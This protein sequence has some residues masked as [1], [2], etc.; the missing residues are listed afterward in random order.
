MPPLQMNNTVF[1][2]GFSVVDL[3]G[4]TPIKVFNP[5]NTS[6]VLL[7]LPEGL[8]IPGSKYRFRLTVNDGSEEGVASMDVE[9]R[10]GP[11]SGSFS[12]EPT[13][14][15]ALDTVTMSGE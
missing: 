6:F 2:P 3:S 9:V 4:Y 8:L 11:T 1:F 12:V 14:V 7:T 15:Q 10:T 5:G 13:T